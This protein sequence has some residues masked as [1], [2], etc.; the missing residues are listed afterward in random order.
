MIVKYHT[1]S[2]TVEARDVI[3]P[4]KS[5]FIEYM[6][7]LGSFAFNMAKYDRLSLR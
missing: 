3:F 7:N 4:V 5:H 6:I 2:S 1:L